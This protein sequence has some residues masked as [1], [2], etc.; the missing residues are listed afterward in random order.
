MIEILVSRGQ[1]FAARSGG[2]STSLGATNIEGRIALDLGL[3]KWEKVVEDSQRAD[4]EED[5]AALVD[6]GPGARWRDVHAALDK[7]GLMVSL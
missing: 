1:V 7:D 6:I 5:F 3:L 2:H 4:G